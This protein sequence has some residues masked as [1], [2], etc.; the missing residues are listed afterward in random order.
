MDDMKGEIKEVFA[1]A[2]VISKMRYIFVII[3]I[4]ECSDIFIRR[5]LEYE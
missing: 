4:S 5:G 1:T 3:L 2:T